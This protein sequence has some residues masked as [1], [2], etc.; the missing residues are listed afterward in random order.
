MSPANIGPES[1]DTVRLGTGD[2]PWVPPK[3]KSHWPWLLSFHSESRRRFRSQVSAASV[4]QSIRCLQGNTVRK[5]LDVDRGNDVFGY[6]TKN[7]GH[8]TKN[9]QVALQ[10]NK[11]LLHGKGNHPQNEKT[12]YG[13]EG[14]ICKSCIC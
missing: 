3:S 9:K 12:A 2:D 4:L 1:Q 14:N 8:K 13:T 10:Q 5:H 7:K 6:D 11:R